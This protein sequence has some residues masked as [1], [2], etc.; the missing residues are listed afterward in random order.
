M[1]FLPTDETG[2]DNVFPLVKAKSSTGADSLFPTILIE[3]HLLRPLTHIINCSQLAGTVP[4]Q[5]KI[6]RIK[7]VLQS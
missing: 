7:P 1:F 4:D 5:M 6:A 2:D 3:A